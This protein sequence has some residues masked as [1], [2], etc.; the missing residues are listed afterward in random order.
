ML[1]CR[2]LL[3]PKIL[4]IQPLQRTMASYSLKPTIGHGILNL[5]GATPESKA[6][7]ERLLEEDR[8][9]Y[10]CFWGNFAGLHNHLS[11]Q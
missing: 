1:L 9:R 10:H 6:T 3:N 8:K 11:H 5:P 2:P 7:V 4:R